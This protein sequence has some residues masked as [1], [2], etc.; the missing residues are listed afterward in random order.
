[1]STPAGWY[2]DG[3]GRQRWWDGQNWT[4]HFAPATPAEPAEIPAQR[5][6]VPAA[7][8]SEAQVPAVPA[9]PAYAAAAQAPAQQYSPPTQT[10]ADHS[11]APQA[12]QKP[13]VLGLVSL[14]LAV[15]GTIAVC[16]PAVMIVGWVLLFAA[17]VVA[18]VAF[19]MKGKKWPAIAGLALSIVG[20]ILGFIMV[21]VFGLF[22]LNSAIDSYDPSTPDSSQT[23]EGTGSDTGVTETSNRPTAQELADGFK[24]LVGLSGAEGYTDEML[25][26]FG[27]EFLASDMSDDTLW[28]I[29]SGDDNFTDPDMALEFSEGLAA[30]MPVCVS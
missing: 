4:E 22:L 10:M 16:I 12:T 27:N 3:S 6:Q 24:I 20:T 5:E 15:L 14:G 8:Q 21:F 17:F 19:F 7:N 18:I 23:D 11:L 29:A 2:D 9:V 26:C 13:S 25:L 1:M 30:A 28:Q